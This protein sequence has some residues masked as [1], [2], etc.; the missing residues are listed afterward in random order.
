MRYF[1]NLGPIGCYAESQK[2]AL[3]RV[4]EVPYHAKNFLVN[5]ESKI[6]RAV[7]AG[8]GVTASG[9]SSAFY[10]GLA[11]LARI[12]PPYSNP[13]QWGVFKYLATGN[14]ELNILIGLGLLALSLKIFDR[15]LVRQSR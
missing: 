14:P 8:I 11:G 15:G 3:H 6:P 13:E 2:D 1:E 7:E 4:R 10:I 9:L 5:V 12:F